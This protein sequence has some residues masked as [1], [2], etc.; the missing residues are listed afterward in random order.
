MLIQ[1]LLEHDDDTLKLLTQ[2]KISEKTNTNTVPPIFSFVKTVDNS[3]VKFYSPIE[4]TKSL[5]N[6]NENTWIYLFEL[7]TPKI[8]H[9]FTSINGYVNENNYQELIAD[10][11]CVPLNTYVSYQKLSNVAAI[12]VDLKRRE[13]K[14]FW[15]KYSQW[16]WALNNPKYIPILA[17]A[18]QRQAKLINYPFK[19]RQ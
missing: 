19:R 8:I 18:A 4:Y 1:H 15:E 9:F 16:Q 13:F 11:L 10:L 6:T 3:S 12:T 14:D 7:R 17:S 2:I 5:Q